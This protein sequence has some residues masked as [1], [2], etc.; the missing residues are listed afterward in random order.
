MLRDSLWGHDE[1]G[2]VLRCQR[3]QDGGSLAE[4]KT[5]L[6][7]ERCA[8]VVLQV[9]DGSNLVLMQPG[10]EISALAPRGVEPGGQP[11]VDGRS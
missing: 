3:L 1:R 9:L 5:H 10:I 2:E 7:H 6:Q 8:G 4:L 11:P